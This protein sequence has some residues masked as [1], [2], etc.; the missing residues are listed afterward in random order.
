MQIEEGKELKLKNL[1]SFR[2]KLTQEEVQ[3]E[4]MELGKLSQ[5]KNLKK[6]G[7]MLKNV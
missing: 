1:I 3:H 2:K 4:M 5:E 7:P 6:S